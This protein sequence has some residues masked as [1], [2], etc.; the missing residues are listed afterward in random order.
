[1]TTI[2]RTKCRVATSLSNGE[3]LSLQINFWPELEQFRYS[4]SGDFKCMRPSYSDWKR[5]KGSDVQEEV[6]FETDRFWIGLSTSISMVCT[7]HVGINI[8]RS[9]TPW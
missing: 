9:S 7:E 5:E 4:P 3:V 6:M 1:M 2:T 8:L